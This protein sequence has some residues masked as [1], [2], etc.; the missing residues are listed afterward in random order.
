SKDRPCQPA[1]SI[2]R[3]NAARP[4][5]V[6][7]S[8]CFSSDGGIRLPPGGPGA[9]RNAAICSAGTLTT[10]YASTAHAADSL[11]RA[12][13]GSSAF[14]LT[15]RVLS[16]RCR[17]ARSPTG[18]PDEGSGRCREL[19]LKHVQQVAHG[20]DLGQLLAGDLDPELVLDLDDQAEDVDR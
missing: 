13:G 4:S 16:D 12:P 9:F 11:A 17:E 2:A 18:L 15:G 8:A 19:G 10:P 20:G 14:A 3:S 1:P 5:T 7:W 6:W